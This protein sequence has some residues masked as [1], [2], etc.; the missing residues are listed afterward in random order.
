MMGTSVLLSKKNSELNLPYSKE[1]TTESPP[2][3]PLALPAIRPTAV[4]RS[5]SLEGS[6]DRSRPGCNGNRQGKTPEVF[7]WPRRRHRGATFQIAGS[8]AAHLMYYFNSLNV[9]PIPC[10]R[11][12]GVARECSNL[13][14]SCAHNLNRL[15]V[16]MRE[17]LKRTLE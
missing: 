14:L 1:P 10:A 7:A 13:R 8:V 17:A 12:L 3:I 2:D 11:G 15:P 16:V 9:G 6:G 4:A 5:R